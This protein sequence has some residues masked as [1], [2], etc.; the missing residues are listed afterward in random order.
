[1]VDAVEKE[2]NIAKSDWDSRT[3]SRQTPLG[4]SR[5]WEDQDWRAD[6]EQ[7]TF[8]LAVAGGEEEDKIGDSK[9]LDRE[10][11]SS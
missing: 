3:M 2:R 11:S 1:V 5:E 10:S 9:I 7:D 8:V 4:S 6:C